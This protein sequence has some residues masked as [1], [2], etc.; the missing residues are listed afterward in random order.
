LPIFLL[1]KSQ[2]LKIGRKSSKKQVY[3]WCSQEIFP[4]NIPHFAPV[5]FVMAKIIQEIHRVNGL[6]LFVKGMNLAF[7]QNMRHKFRAG[8]SVCFRYGGFAENK[9][10]KEC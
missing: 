6:N 5:N 4:C 2:P 8:S 7:R 10:G 9:G 1:E 3:Q